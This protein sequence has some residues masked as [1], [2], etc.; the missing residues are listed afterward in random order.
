MGSNG[1]MSSSGTPVTG[2][3]LLRTLA[4]SHCRSQRVP[5]YSGTGDEV[6]L[7][8]NGGGE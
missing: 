1:G 3:P 8:H 6:A 5:K 7:T 2:S 4:Y